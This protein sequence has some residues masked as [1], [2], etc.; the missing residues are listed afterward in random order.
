[1]PFYREYRGYEVHFD[2]ADISGGGVLWLVKGYGVERGNGAASSRQIAF[3]EAYALVDEIESESDPYRFPVNL[4][5]YPETDQGDV[6]T[7]DGEALGRWR[8]VDDHGL[9]MV[10][11]I[12]DGS[13]A[14]LFRDYRIGLLCQDIQEWHVEQG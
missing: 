4:V 12:P 9:K 6:V 2:E 10:E 14:V 11:F 7:R 8:S 13:D 3:E 1:M 5:G